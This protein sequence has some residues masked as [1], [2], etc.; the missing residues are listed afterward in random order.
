MAENCLDHGVDGGD[1]VRHARVVELDD[2]PLTVDGDAVRLTALHGGSVEAQSLG[3]GR[4]SV[5]TVRLPASDAVVAAPLA[6]TPHPAPPAATRILVVDDNEDAAELLSVALADRGHTVAVAGDGAT[7]IARAVEF[8]PR[9]VLLDIGL[10]GIDGYEVAA[11]LRKQPELGDC[12]II[13][14]TG[15]GQEQDRRRSR[16]AGFD[17]HL[18]KPVDLNQLWSLFADRNVQ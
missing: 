18:V 12:L 2:G 17:E 4:G 11:R 1:L 13:G 14:I 8:K 7:A 15:Y 16:D 9:V 3:E 10:P 6:A 5:F